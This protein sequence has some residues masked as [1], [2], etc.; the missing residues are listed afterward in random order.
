MEI[1]AFNQPSR[2][3]VFK[4]VMRNIDCNIDHNILNM[5]VTFHS[6]N[7]PLILVHLA[8]QCSWELC[9]S[10][11]VHCRHDCGSA[12]GSNYVLLTSALTYSMS[13]G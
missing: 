11:L 5:L 1:V 4:Q 10:A 2:P 12:T 9:D 3:F 13:Y 7:L 6:F 8:M